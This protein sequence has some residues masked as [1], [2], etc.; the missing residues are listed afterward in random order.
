MPPRVPFG[1][2]RLFGR[3]RPKTAAPARQGAKPRAAVKSAPAAVNCGL[4]ACPIHAALRAAPTARTIMR[5]FALPLL[6]IVLAAPCLAQDR[7]HVRPSRS[8][9]AR[10]A[11]APKSAMSITGIL[12]PKDAADF[13]AKVEADL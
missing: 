5:L 8:Q 13:I 6:T 7:D 9:A 1:V 2:A 11:L 3:P 4:S 12:S 10:P